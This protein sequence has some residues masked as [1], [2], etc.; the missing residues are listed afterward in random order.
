MKVVIDKADKVFSDY[1]RTRDNWTCVRCKRHDP[2]TTEQKSALQCSHYFGRARE[3]VRF[4]EQNADCLCMGCHQFWGSTN[5]E[6]YRAFKIKQLGQRDFDLLTIEA[7]SYAKKDRK[8]AY[9]YWKERL[10]ELAT[11]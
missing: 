1:I 11:L 5:R 2:V 3:S 9:I 7:N 6:D 4:N 8:L 10:E